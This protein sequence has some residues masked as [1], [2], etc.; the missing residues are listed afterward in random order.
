M[1]KNAFFIHENAVGFSKP[2]KKGINKGWKGG[3]SPHE[4]CAKL[5]ICILLKFTLVSTLQLYF[6]LSH[7][8]LLGIMYVFTTLLEDCYFS[9]CQSAFVN[10]QNNTDVKWLV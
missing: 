1:Y 2:D 7:S 9:H 5:L 10:Q 8:L 4:L 6:S 3:N